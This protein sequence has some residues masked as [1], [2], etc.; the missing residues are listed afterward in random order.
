MGGFIGPVNGKT[1]VGYLFLIKS[2]NI[3]YIVGLI[4]KIKYTNRI[5]FPKDDLEDEIKLIGRRQLTL[6]IRI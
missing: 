6:S 4:S 3:E 2:N 1:S 5:I